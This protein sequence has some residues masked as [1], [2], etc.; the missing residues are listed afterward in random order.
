[1]ETI[2]WEYKGLT[3]IMSEH[4]GMYGLDSKRAELHKEIEKYFP[5]KEEDLKTVLHNLPVDFS[6]KDLCWAVKDIVKF[7][8]YIKEEGIRI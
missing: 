8:Q 2:F 7:R 5:G 3:E 4:P 1:M 6:F